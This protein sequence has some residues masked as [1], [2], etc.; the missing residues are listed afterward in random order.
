MGDIDCLDPDARAF[1]QVDNGLADARRVDEELDAGR[2]GPAK[3][4]CG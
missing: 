3:S 2:R 4:G 1:E